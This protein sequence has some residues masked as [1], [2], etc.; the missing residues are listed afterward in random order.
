MRCVV[1]I[2]LILGL[3]AVSGCIPVS[4]S[5]VCSNGGEA[6]GAQLDAAPNPQRVAALTD[7]LRALGPRVS[8]REAARVAEVAVY[9]SESLASHYKMVR[10][11]EL[12][13]VMVNVGLRKGGL[14]YEMADYMLAELQ[15]L[16]LRTLELQL[17]VAWKGD[18]WNEHNCVVVT[19]RRQSFQSGVVLDAW[20]NGGRLRWA[21]VRMDHYPWRPKP[22]KL[23]PP[24]A[25]TLTSAA[26]PSR[27][28]R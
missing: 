1:G 16:P 23:N 3:S 25:L 22:P 8:P 21:P 17:G 4:R 9:Y 20:R 5:S 27:V 12:H 24:P 26:G 10:P 28:A 2:L 13:N 19:A 18:L 11:V 14:C 6:R 7:E 15:K